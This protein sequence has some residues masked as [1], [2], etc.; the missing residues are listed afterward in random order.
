MY[1]V[2]VVM[3]VPLPGHGASGAH[4]DRVHA[5]NRTRRQAFAW[6]LAPAKPRNSMH[7]PVLVGPLVRVD[8]YACEADH[9]LVDVERVPGSDDV[10][11]GQLGALLK[12]ELSGVVPAC[13][14]CEREMVWLSTK[15]RKRL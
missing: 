6:R 11:S 3:L 12:E 4:Q 5:V 14:A 7:R 10:Q 13:P 9:L 15:F 1:L 2:R 8:S